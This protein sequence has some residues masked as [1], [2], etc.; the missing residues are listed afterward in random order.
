MMN[1][2]I[3]FSKGYEVKYVSH[4]DLMRTFNR[5]LMRSG[6]PVSY[7]Q[8]FNPHIILTFAQPLSVG[9]TSDGEYA[10]F[11]MEEQCTF[12]EIKDK[13]NAAAPEGIEILKVTDELA[14]KF[15]EL[16]AA[17]YVVTLQCNQPKE[18]L[19]NVLNREVIPVEKKTKKGLKEI[20]IKPLLFDFSIEEEAES[21]MLTLKLA[22][23]SE[24]NLNPD[25]LLKA[26]EKEI[27]GFR[28]DYKSVHRIKLLTKENEELMK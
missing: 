28:M 24:R 4:L 25:L 7:T 6:L 2:R 15:K 19:L 9:V 16:Y 27:P 18:A 3:Q 10:E 12:D 8:G 22:S 23:G 20:D 11:Q 21:L 14:P 1:V 26:F 13:L 5:M 17:V